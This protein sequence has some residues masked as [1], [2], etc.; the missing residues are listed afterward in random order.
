MI[1]WCLLREKDLRLI[2]VWNPG[3]LIQIINFIS[4]HFKALCYDISTGEVHLPHPGIS[5]D[6]AIAETLPA[7][8]PRRSR[9]LTSLEKIGPSTIPRIWPRLRL[10]SCWTDAWAASMTDELRKLFPGVEINTVDGGF[11]SSGEIECF[12]FC[13]SLTPVVDSVAE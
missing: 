5:T 6:K 10:I 4:K 12:F 9:F 1:S 2:S 8:K 7:G 3:L 11:R 13:N